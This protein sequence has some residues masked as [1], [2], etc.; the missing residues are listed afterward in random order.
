MLR[1]EGVDI[2]G[3]YRTRI[4]TGELSLRA[5]GTYVRKL[6]LGSG[7]TIISRDGEVG[8]NGRNGEYGVPRWRGL[9][10]VSYRGG[11]ATIAVTSRFVGASRIESDWTSLDIDRNRVPAQVYFDLYGAMKVKTDR[12]TLEIFVSAENVFDRDPPL[13]PSTSSLAFVT[14]PVN[15]QVYD[16]LGR[17]VRV[18]ARLTF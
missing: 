11:P 7:A 13:V 17:S 1:S 6:S 8:D 5:F 3:G 14:P 2:E 12:R 16:T 10:T 15:P 9:G 18:G 4:G